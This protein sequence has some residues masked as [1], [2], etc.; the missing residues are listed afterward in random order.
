M[1]TLNF[2]PIGTESTPWGETERQAWYH[3]CQIQRRYQTVLDDIHALG[4]EFEL[5]NYGAL[6]IDAARYPLW[7]IKSCDWQPTKPWVLVTGGVHGYETSGVHGALGF[8]RQYGAEY[9]S[10]VNWLVLPCISPWGYETINRWGPNAVDPNRSFVAGSDSEEA[11]AVMALLAD[12]NCPFKLHIDLHET[13]DT[14]ESEFRPALA[15]RDGKPYEAGIIPDGFYLVGDSHN[16]Q[17]EFQRII[18][19]AVAAVTH[20]A[21]S[22]DNGMIIGAPVEQLGVINYPVK[23][24][25][26]CAGVTDSEYCTTTEVYP[27]SPNATAE[28]CNQAQIAAVRAAIDYVLAN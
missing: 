9:A 2:Y 7:A 27:D 24:L 10:K 15:A 19:A 28:Q 17:T 6:S 1:N 18:I 23:A 22:D 11:Q 14:D 16:P 12:F 20:I 8:V 5:I 4:S 21:P 3:S 26:L 25:G 13:T